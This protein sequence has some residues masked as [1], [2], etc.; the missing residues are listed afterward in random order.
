[1]SFLTPEREHEKLVKREKKKTS[2]LFSEMN[3][4]GLA[5]GATQIRAN[6]A[7]LE[8]VPEMADVEMMS[9]RRRYGEIVEAVEQGVEF[10]SLGEFLKEFFFF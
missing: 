8:R 2:I 7:R 5:K 6:V 9:A 3:A 4:D 10:D 1:M